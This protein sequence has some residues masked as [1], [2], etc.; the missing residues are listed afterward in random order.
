MNNTVSTYG[1]SSTLEITN[2]VGY[3]SGMY[4]CV[5]INIAGKTTSVYG[6]LS[7]K[8]KSIIQ[9]LFWV[10]LFTAFLHV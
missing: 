8:G 7:V 2:V 6:N 9:Y 10:Q 3:Y 5:A 4:C 1:V